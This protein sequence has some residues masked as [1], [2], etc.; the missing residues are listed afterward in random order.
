MRILPDRAK[1]NELFIP[2]SG[3]S[4]N[5]GLGIVSICVLSIIISGCGKKMFP[6]PHGVAPPPQVKDL[7]TRVMPRSV[8]LSWSP[9]AG[10]AVKGI[11]YAITRSDLK[12]ENRNCL[13]CPAPERQRVQSIDAAA[14]KPTADGKLRWVDTNVLYRR[15]FSYQ[16]VVTDEKGNALSTS[17][18]AI[19]K[20]YPGPAAPA[21]VTA[22]TQPRGVLIQW[23]P[24]LK[25]LEGNNLDAASVSFR[26]ERLSGDKGW[27][28][29][30]PSPVKGNAYYD[31]SIAAEQSY[32]YRV[33]AAQYIDDVY[34]YGEPSSTIL[35]KG[36]ES[37]PPPPP[38]KVWIT[39]AHG[40]LE[41]HWTE[42]DGKT[43]GYHVYRKEGKEIIRLTASP[44][45]HPP[46]VDQGAKKGLT[47]FYAVSAVSAQADHKEGLLSK[48][49]EVR[50]LLG[51]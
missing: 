24:V 15:A 50:H 41:I 46:F 42:T 44:V 1:Y 10:E 32:S 19:A 17:S 22:A 21:N 28:I 31:Q 43:G 35:V 26:V 4:R 38:D 13:E 29:A 25:D 18:P 48:W 16:I 5:K 49:T 20:V 8:E 9:A 47:Y 23:K 33:V 2:F 27:E 37:V 12:W 7:K 40:A 45:Q 34:I 30:S 14:A 6:K 3:F 51:D 11:G 36:P 39:P